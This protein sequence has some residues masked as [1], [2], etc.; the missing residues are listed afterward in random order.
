MHEGRGAGIVR[1]LVQRCERVGAELRTPLDL[2]RYARGGERSTSLALRG[3]RGVRGVRGSSPRR[4]CFAFGS[5]GSPAARGSTV[6]LAAW[7]SGKHRGTHGRK[8]HTQESGIRKQAGSVAAGSGRRSR[9]HAACSRQQAA[10]SQ[11]PAAHGEH[12]V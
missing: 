1:A 9:K 10:S 4:H 3:E 2:R 5:N 12:T 8:H 6:R 11:R 7:Y